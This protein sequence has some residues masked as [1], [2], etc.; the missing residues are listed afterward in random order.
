MRP[1]RAFLSLLVLLLALPASAAAQQGT[2]ALEGAVEDPSGAVLPG[3]TVT[4]THRDT[5]TGRSVVT[6]ERGRYRMQAL[7]TGPYVVTAELTGFT[8]ATREV[9]LLIGSEITANL[10][11]AL[12]TVQESVQVTASA[13]MIEVTK[14]HVSST[15]NEKQISELPLISRNFLTLAALVPG[16]GRATSLVATQPLQIGGADARTN[17]TTII[18]GGDLDDDIWGA[19]VQSF[20]QD[21]I[22]EFQVITNRFDAEYGKALEAVVNVVS[23]SGTNTLSGTAFLFDRDDAF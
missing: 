21:S 20:M 23:K 22:K 11:L 18:D 7:P 4:A 17:Y 9:I 13:P 16:A 15:I 19:P 1:P 3:V 14:S 2:A 12:S 10:R 5:G 6:D 8:A